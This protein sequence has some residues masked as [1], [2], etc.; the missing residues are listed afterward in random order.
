MKRSS[1]NS[2]YRITNDVLKS[3]EYG[4]GH[5]CDEDISTMVQRI[6][7]YIMT[8]PPGEARSFIEHLVPVLAYGWGHGNDATIGTMFLNLMDWLD[9]QHPD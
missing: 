3:L 5:R 2:I 6:V 7:R 9:R 4:W 1:G 8:Q